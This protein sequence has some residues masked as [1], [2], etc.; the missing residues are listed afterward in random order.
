MINGVD[1]V[2]NCNIERNSSIDLIKVIAIIIIVFSHGMPDSDSTTAGY[3]SAIDLNVASTDI[4]LFIIR[5]LHNLGQIGNDIFLVC[6]SW[7]LLESR[8]VNV[9]KITSMVGDCFTISI[10]MLIIFITIGYKFS[11]AYIIRQFFPITFNNTWYLTCYL[12]LYSI[13]PI[14]NI[15]INNI[16]SSKLFMINVI[17]VVLYCSMSFVLGGRLFYYNNF[18]GFVIIYFIVAYYKKYMSKVS[19]KRFGV[20]ILLIGLAGWIIETLLLLVVG[21]KIEILSNQLQIINQFINPC[22]I[23]IALGALSIAKNIKFSNWFI[24]YMSSMTLLIYVIHCNR[25]VRDYVRFDIFKYILEKYTYSNVLLWVVFYSLVS[26]V[27]AVFLAFL[28]RI[29][30]QKIIHRFFDRITSIL[31]SMYNYIEKQ[32]LYKLH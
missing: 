30:L 16:T 28:Y 3:A 5:L 20:V 31:I 9:K 24:S 27:G 23:I 10:L 12:L 25:I 19:N 21:L 4:Q 15:I 2:K 7:F 11:G 1:Q 26:L 6:S 17:C 29:T 8:K 32:F 18:I 22:F 13:H 14:L